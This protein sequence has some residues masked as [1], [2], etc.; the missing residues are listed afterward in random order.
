MWSHDPRLTGDV[1]KM[2]KEQILI[3]VGDSLYFYLISLS[4]GLFASPDCK[5][6]T[7]CVC[8]SVSNC[9]TAKVIY[10]IAKQK[11]LHFLKMYG[12]FVF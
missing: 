10:V 8:V 6:F 5:L 12:H 7:F 1:V 9:R 4:C 2:D 3:S 11:K